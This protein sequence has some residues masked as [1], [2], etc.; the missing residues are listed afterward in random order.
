MI[1]AGIEP[2]V[3][4]PMQSSVN[5]LQLKSI[6]LDAMSEHS[7]PVLIVITQEVILRESIREM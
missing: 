4:N 2:P 7:C 5:V 1:H 3:R 6:R